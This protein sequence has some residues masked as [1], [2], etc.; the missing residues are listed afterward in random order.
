MGEE[1]E[2]LRAIEKAA[3]RVWVSAIPDND[4]RSFVS[5]S[6]LEGLRK[7]LWPGDGT[8]EHDWID[9][10]TIGEAAEGTRTRQCT[11]CAV[12]E[13]EYRAPYG[14][15]RCMAETPAGRCV[16]PMGHAEGHT[17]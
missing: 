3:Q 15:V 10:S 17:A 11:I 6:A 12:T 5:T 16:A 1:I 13:C 4:R 7:A 8:C 9:I 14:A 2:R